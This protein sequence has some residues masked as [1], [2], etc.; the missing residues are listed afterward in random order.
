MVIGLLI[1]IPLL[2][3]IV[4]LFFGVGEMWQ[5]IV[6]HFLLDYVKNS[7]VLLL[8][9]GVLCFLFGTSTAWIIA[10]YEFRFRK[11]IEWLLFLPLAIPSYIVAYAYVGLLGNG[12]TLI[13]GSQALGIP[14]E[15]VEMMNIYGLIWVLSCSLYPY[16]Y[17]SVSAMFKSFPTR[18]REASYLLGASS[19]R[20]FFSI[21]LPLASPAIIGGLFLVFMEVLN[22]YGAAKYYGIQT[23]TTGIF[24]TWTMLED[25]QSAVYLSALLVVIVFIING[26]IRWQRGEKSYV[27]KDIAAKQQN[28]QRKSW[29]GSQKILFPLILGTPILFGLILPVG[30]LLY[31]AFLTFE[32]MFTAELFSIALQSLGLAFVATFFIVITAL[33]LIFFS[34]WNHVKSIRLIQKIATIGYVIPGAIIGIGI[35]RS[36]QTFI[37]FF[38]D[39]LHLKIGFLFYGSSVILIYAY[40][41]RFLAVAFNPLESNSLKLGKYLSESSY[42]LG[43]SKFK[44]LFKIELPLLRNVLISTFLLVF[45]DILKELPLTLILKPYHLQTL[46]IKTYEYADDERVAEAAIPALLLILIIVLLLIL[47]K[48]LDRFFRKK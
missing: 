17:G 23:F 9:T 6:S 8:G 21:A 3:I 43:R 36:S 40:V 32:T 12:G 13:R 20:Y 45:I 35:M 19:W 37:N 44:T 25:L 48:F 28:A 1:A 26:L 5:H 30:Q 42:L 7:F 14:I 38:A 11:W 46:A 24:R 10:N 34:R 41:F 2:A 33:I 18:I 16:V 22:D 15:K 31:W 47:I 29:C 27:L 4:Y 39:T